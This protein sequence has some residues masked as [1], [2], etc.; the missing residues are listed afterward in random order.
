MDKEKIL[1]QSRAEKSDEGV[2]YAKSQGRKFGFIALLAI[3]TTL[4]LLSFFAENIQV[5]ASIIY[6]LAALLFACLGA[7]ALG[8]YLHRRRTQTLIGTI[9]NA[10][11]AIWMGIMFFTSLIAL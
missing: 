1:A 7:D 2:E 10:G 4:M 9:F 3:S 8:Q 11:M 5:S 6:A